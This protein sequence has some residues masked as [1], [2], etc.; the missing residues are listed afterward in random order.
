MSEPLHDTSLGMTGRGPIDTPRILLR[1][2]K[3]VLAFAVIQE[4]GTVDM[5]VIRPGH[6]PMSILGAILLPARTPK[7]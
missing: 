3:T 1:A 4:D 6:E 2:G 7:V 5:H